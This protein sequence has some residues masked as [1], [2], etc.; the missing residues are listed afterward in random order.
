MRL[1]MNHGEAVMND[2]SKKCLL[3]ED[4]Y[5]IVGM[6]LRMTELCPAIAREQ[7]KKLDS[8]IEQYQKL[9]RYFN[10]P[11]RPDCT[12]AY[13]KFASLDME[14]NPNKKLF[15]MKDHY[16]TPLYLMP[17]FEQ[18]GYEKGLCPVCEDVENKI[19]LAWLKEVL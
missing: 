1:C 5:K 13:Y 10:I 4:Y 19:K 6:N 18:L 8:I 3:Y 17:L 15:H 14:E 11:V 16:I 9:A 7:L 2:I 12:T